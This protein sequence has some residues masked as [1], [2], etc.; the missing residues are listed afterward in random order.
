MKIQVENLCKTYSVHHKH[1]GLKASIQALFHREFKHIEAVRQI[2]F[3]LQTGDIIGF[4]GPNGAG[5]TTTLKMLSGL[6]HPTSGTIR[7]DT[8][9]P[10]KRE[11]T[12]L[13]SLGFVMG[14][15]GQLWWDLPALDSYDLLIDIY[16][17]D[18]RSTMA[19]VHELAEQL[20]IHT[21]LKQPVKML[22]LGQRMKAELIGA[23]LHRPSI[24]ILDEPTIGLDISSAREIR[25]IIKREATQREMI[26][27]IS[28]H[29]L[30]DIEELCEKIIIINNGSIVYN[31]ALANCYQRYMF[32]KLLQ[33][34]FN[35]P[36]QRNTL[37]APEAITKYTP[38]AVNWELDRTRI[39][40]MSYELMQQFSI[41][42]MTISEI[43]LGKVIEFITES[44]PERSKRAMSAKPNTLKPLLNNVLNCASLCNLAQKGF[45]E[46]IHYS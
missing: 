13:R 35:A 17:C 45:L 36:V 20:S 41:D 26:V 8:H 37:P 32:Q 11:K 23:I 5:K 25:R 43:P 10:W 6:L 46:W 40:P 42:D 33:I 16:E 18:R 38:Y 9:I 31:D 7:A 28:S 15:K 29:I 30:D 1:P 2:N 21:H 12:F 14:Q 4:I 24:L 22:S 44:T 3:T 39:A 34:K 27:I 19:Y